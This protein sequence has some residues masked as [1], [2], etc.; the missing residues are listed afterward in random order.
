MRAEIIDPTCDAIPPEWELFRVEHKVSAA[1]KADVLTPL[2]WCSQRTVL[3]G[4]VYDRLRPLGLCMGEL[5]S[6]FPKAE[7]YATP[8]RLPR[9]GWF[10]CR[11]LL[12]FT[13][14]FAFP[15]ELPIRDRAVALRAFESALRRR[16]GLGYRGILYWQITDNT[17]P[18]VGG[19]LRARLPTAP[20]TVLINRWGSMGDYLSSLPKHRRRAF[21][22]LHDE[23]AAEVEVLTAVPRIDSK[24]A[25]NLAHFTKLKHVRGHKGVAPIPE[26]YFERLNDSEGVTYFGHRVG[27]RLLAFDLAFC[28]AHRLTTT[29][30][31]TLDMRDGGQ[32]HLYFD[33]YLTEIQHMVQQGLE[34]IEFGKGML[35]LKLRFGSEPIP[36]YLVAAPC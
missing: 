9:I 21:A 25:S 19:T 13:E 20:N 30:N 29:V 14:G 15:P 17:I 1:W 34:S 31:G 10:N 26:A 7:R 11:L 18:V 35:D 33:V 36:Q 23:T 6:F 5:G 16:V 27:S 3:L 2:A 24:Q 32:R 8:G 22:R 4:I 28:D 12:G